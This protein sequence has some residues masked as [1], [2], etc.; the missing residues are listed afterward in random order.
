MNPIPRALLRRA[1]DRYVVD[2]LGTGVS[3]LR[4][5]LTLIEALT[6]DARFRHHWRPVR[7][8][9]HASGAVDPDVLYTAA[10]P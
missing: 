7:P 4:T 10:P 8:E 3:D 6:A 9:A 5:Y 1:G 2:C